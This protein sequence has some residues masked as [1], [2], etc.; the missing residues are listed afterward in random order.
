MLWRFVCCVS[1]RLLAA[2]GLFLMTTFNL[3]LSD[4][5]H[6]NAA[7]AARL[8]GN[9]GLSLWGCCVVFHFVVPFRAIPCLLYTCVCLFISCHVFLQRT[10][11]DK[12]HAALRS[13]VCDSSARVLQFSVGIPGGVSDSA[14]SLCGLLN[15]GLLR[16]PALLH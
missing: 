11:F 10:D 1:C 3:D 4:T 13:Y 8:Y 15:S 6:L 5:V 14:A 7:V 16:T 12:R 9:F 2:L